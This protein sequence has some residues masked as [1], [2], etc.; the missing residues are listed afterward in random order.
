MLSSL[1]SVTFVKAMM[2]IVAIAFVGLIVLEWGADFSGRGGPNVGDSIG[3]VNGQKISHQE[4]ENIL[5][6]AYRQSKETTGEPDLIQL[7]GKTWD[8]MVNQTLLAQEIEKH[9]VK[10]SDEEVNFFNRVQPAQWVKNQEFFQTDSTFD[11]EKYRKFLDDPST[12]SNPQMKEFVLSAESAARQVLLNQ[13]LQELIAGSVRVTNA[14]ARDAYLNANEKIRIA[15]VG[16][17]ITAYHDSLISLQNSEIQSYYDANRDEF[18]QNDAVDASFV[19]FLKTPSSQDESDVASEIQQVLSKIRTGQDFSELA[20]LYSDD[21]GSA[22]KG[23]DLGFFGRGR[24]VKAFEDTAFSLKPGQISEPFRTQFGWHIL[25]VESKTG[26]ADSLQVRAR[27]ILLQI[28]P[29]RNTLDS[30]RLQI[31]EFRNI[32]EAIGFDAAVSQESL[33]YN[34]TGFITV[35]SFLP[36]LGHRTYG[37]VKSFLDA[38]P[39]DISSSYET[40]QAIYVFVLRKKRS[41]GPQPLNEVRSQIISR[42]KKKKKVALASE[43]IAAILPQ[44]KSGKSLKKISDFHS[45]RYDE[46]KPFSRSDFVPNVGSQNAFTGAAFNLATKTLSDVVTTDR[47]AYILKI[48]ERKTI[49]ESKFQAEKHATILRLLNQK[50]NEL[51]NIWFSDLKSNAEIVDNRHLFYTDF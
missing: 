11:P 27:H 8:Q 15:Y 50:R 49:D 6:N 4:F 14:E 48:L 10:V 24:M 18:H 9:Q 34:D 46:P 51:L 16:T 3:T 25:K 28:R 12:Y 32:A 23:G 29:G 42:L 37:L 30:L 5:K 43:K 36:I 44:V 1:R 26:A 47:G 13:R 19:S 35:G 33:T 17:E 21:P 20:Q 2:W 22:K 39:D 7:V 41:S 31:Q 45:L 40:D 38:S